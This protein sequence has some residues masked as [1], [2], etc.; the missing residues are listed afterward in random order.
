MSVP[1]LLYDPVV[2]AVVTVAVV[3][4]MQYQRTLSWTEYRFIHRLKVR[5]A[6]W[7]AR[8]TSFLLITHKGY[9]DDA[10]YLL[11][12]EQSVRE[13]WQ[14]LVG[15]GGSPHLIN[16][17]KERQTP[18]GP[19]FSDAHVVWI[20]QG[21]QTEA[22]LFGNPDGSTDVYAHHEPAV[23]NADAHLDGPQTNGDPEGV[24]RDAL[25]VV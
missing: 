9:R 14:T 5:L 17:V 19:Q 2:L 16:S 3:A 23:H 1:D 22:Y 11:T 6:P 10:E 25:G 24:V 18:D 21:M 7:G 12:R 13:V 4:L 15:A 8:N 20:D